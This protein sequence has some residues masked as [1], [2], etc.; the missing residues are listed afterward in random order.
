MKRWLVLVLGV[1]ACGDN[2]HSAR[3]VMDVGEV[4][5]A[6]GR[7]PFPTDALIEGRNIGPIARL[8]RMAKQ[9]FDL[10]GAHLATLDGWGLRPT[11][12]FF[13]EGELDADSVPIAT[14]ELSDALVVLDVDPNTGEDGAAIPFEWRYIRD[15]DTHRNYIAGSPAMGTQLR[16]GTR[17]AAVLTKDVKGIDGTPVFGARELGLLEEGPPARWQTTADAYTHL[18][19]F[20]AL[21]DRI[22]GIAVFTTQNASD[23][24]VKARNEI[25]NTSAVPAPTLTFDDDELIFDTPG[26]LTKLLG[27]AARETAGPRVGLERWGTDNANGMAHD[28]IAV[29]ATGKTTIARFI[30]DDT[31]TD[32]PED[33]TFALGANGVPMVRS[34]DTIPIT[35]ILP[36][37]PMPA[38]GFPVIVFGHG[39][40]GSRRDM[41]N[42]AEPLCAKGYAMIGI[43]MWNHGLRLSTTDTGNNLGSK[44]DF[45]GDRTI[46]DG[47]SD[48]ADSVAYVS[49]FESF[50]NLSAIRDSIRQSALDISRVAL[51]IQTGPS[52]LDLRGPFGATTPKL[53]KTR[54]AYLGQSFGTIV[55][56][57]LAAIEPTIGLYVLNVAGG[58]LLDQIFPASAK[59]GELAV[60]LAE[61]LYRTQGTLDR[62][63]P[64]VGAMQAT[65]DGADS[66]TFARHVLKDRFMID[67]AYLDRR[68]VVV[69]EAIGDEIMP[70]RA[71]EALARSFGLHLLRPN[72]QAPTGMLQIESPGAGNVNNQ[73]AILVQ[74][75]PA[76][77]G[78]NWSAERG[79][80]EY[81]P[82]YPFAGDVPYPKLPAKIT[83]KEPIYETLDQVSEI[84]ESYF[85]GENPRVRS[86]LAP[87]ADFDGDGK[88]DTSDAYPFDPTK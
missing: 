72:V 23:T 37:T 50:M 16:E 61:Q 73:T 69:I 26:K 29:I 58:G 85:A 35:V 87:V 18:K 57:D 6:Y 14:R 11:V 59:I 44:P 28:H 32:G 60:P 46:R 1:V 24:L 10:I 64:L 55:G 78:Y 9:H 80:L 52:L 25:S 5:P 12:Q 45:T 2:D 62:F 79:E 36:N 76:T 74:Y 48:D 39:L 8:D 82:G 75:E 7:S 15:R 27:N 4:A 41:L 38:T 43:D 19:T 49:F 47:F 33:E 3:V 71:T 51:L 81:Q 83:I 30:G 77:H 53:D 70:N 54:V 67:N 84:L 34:V 65:F 17:Y 63:H 40:G 88:P 20:S 56:T 13:I 68:H 31:G 66:L 21:E 42:L 22:A 86:T